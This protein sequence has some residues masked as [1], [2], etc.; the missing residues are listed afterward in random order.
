MLAGLLTLALAPLASASVVNVRIEG[1]TQTLFEGPVRTEGHQIR[2]SSDTQQRECNGTNSGARASPGPTPTAAAVDAMSLLGE[3]FDG[4]WSSSS[5]DYFITRWGPEAQN[6]AEGEYWGLLVDD[7]FLSVG[8]CQYELAEGD[9]VL[10][11]YDAF[12]HDRFLTLYGASESRTAAIPTPTVALGQPFTVKVESFNGNEGAF[13]SLGPYSGAEVSPVSTAAN[14]FQTVDT[15]S[16]ESVTTTGEG[17]ATITFNTPGWHRLK[18]TAGKTFRSDRLDVCVPAPGATSCGALPSDDQ[19]RP[20]EQTPREK[21]GPPTGPGGTSTHPEPGSSMRRPPGK[22][23]P[24]TLKLDGLALSP[25]DDRSPRIHYRG[26]WRRVHESRAW[27]ATVSIGRPGARLSINLGR[28]RPVFVL[29]D[30]RHRARIEVIEGAHHK[31]FAVLSIAPGQSRALVTSR[32]IDP[33]YIELRVV[34]GTVGVDAIA[35]A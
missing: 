32:L 7:S 9:Q 28:G 22:G 24:V 3:S 5:Q 27:N 13:H 35:L 10:W 15:G 2:A 16:S 25:I 14:G 17:T 11:A 33:G 31:S 29:R 6:A 18:A 4:Q 23:A 19:V 1:G 12:N 8:G 34:D 20:S 30:V 26:R 21:P